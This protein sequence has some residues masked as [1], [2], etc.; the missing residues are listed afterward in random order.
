VRWNYRMLRGLTAS[1]NNTVQARLRVLPVAG[2]RND[3][4]LDSLRHHA[5]GRAH[6][7]G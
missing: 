3:L 1:Q 7:R 2:E 4:S 6:C 5:D